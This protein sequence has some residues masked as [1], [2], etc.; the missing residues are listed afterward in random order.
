MS[1]AK[2]GPKSLNII[3]S[4][5]FVGIILVWVVALIQIAFFIVSAMQ[6]PIS[7]AELKSLV[8]ILLLVLPVSAS[9]MQQLA[10]LILHTA[11]LGGVI[12]L[13]DLRNHSVKSEPNDETSVKRNRSNHNVENKSLYSSY[14]ERNR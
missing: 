11:I 2:S 7:L 4:L 14:N 13:I 1:R 5:C 8:G 3:R 12:A 10:M 6:T 9:V